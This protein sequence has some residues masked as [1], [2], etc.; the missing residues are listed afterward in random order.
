VVG[1]F[2][3]EVSNATNSFIGGGFDNILSLCENS[4]IIAGQ[5]NVIKTSASDNFIG[6]GL[7]NRIEG[8]TY[9]GSGRNAILAGFSNEIYDVSTNCAIIAGSSNFIQNIA[10]QSIAIDNGVIVGGQGNRMLRGTNHI[11]LGGFSNTVQN[12]LGNSNS[13][14]L[15][16][17]RHYCT[18]GSDAG[19]VGGRRHRVTGSGYANV[20]VAGS[21]NDITAGSN[22]GIF[23]GRLNTITT[24]GIDNAIVGGQ[25]LTIGTTLNRSVAIGGNNFSPDLSDQVAIGGSMRIKTVPLLSGLSN[26][27]LVWNQPTNLRVFRTSFATSD[28]RLKSNITELAPEVFNLSLIKQI[29][30]ISFNKKSTSEII[31]GTDRKYGFSAQNLQ[32]VI[33]WAIKTLEYNEEIGDNILGL[34]SMALTAFLAGTCKE[35]QKLIEAQQTEIDDLKILTQQLADRISAL[36]NN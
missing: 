22:G 12:T 20:V 2:S 31:Y 35:Q 25:S 3:S 9:V 4:G 13:F 30:P 1:G 18:I 17:N 7:R 14:V 6:G 15:G 11:I 19:I 32:N 10:L 36:E 26:H 28:E 5:S 21:D 24:S 34:D 23:A 27:Y 29:T 33:P 16:G 8:I